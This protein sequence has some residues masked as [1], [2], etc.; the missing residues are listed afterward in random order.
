MLAWV[1]AMLDWVAIGPA[2]LLCPTLWM[3][4]SEDRATIASV[5]EYQQAL[6]GSSVQVDVIEGLDHE[7]VFFEV[8]RDF[9]RMVAFS[10]SV[11]HT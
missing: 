6:D 11:V 10:E 5:K 1:R 3:V 9:P 8:D 7:G 2:D 4:G